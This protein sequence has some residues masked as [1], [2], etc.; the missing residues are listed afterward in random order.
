ME[1]QDRNLAEICLKVDGSEDF[2]FKGRIFSECSWYD[3]EF[4][5]QTR[6]KLYVTDTSDQIYYIV[7]SGAEKSRK[8]YRLSCDN[9]IYT[10]W[11]GSFQISL[12][13]EMLKIALR[14]LCGCKEEVEP[15]VEEMLGAVNA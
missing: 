10:I 2:V 12:T 1:G 4:G 7:R 3:E 5:I 15:A 14:S 11:N 6:Q 9:G 13:P 8:A